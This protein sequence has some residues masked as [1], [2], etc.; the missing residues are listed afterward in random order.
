MDNLSLKLTKLKTKGFTLVELS[1]VIVIIGLIVAGVVGGQAI[2]NQAKLRKVITDY[3]AYKVAF[4]A[5]KLEYNKLPGD[6]DNATDY[7]PSASTGNGDNNGSIQFSETVTGQGFESL[8][9]FQ[10]LA[11]ADIIPGS[12]SY[13]GNVWN[14][15]YN[16]DAGPFPNSIY[17]PYTMGF[18]NARMQVGMILDDK[19]PAVNQFRGVM[20]AKDMFSVDTKADDG[21]VTGGAIRALSTWPHQANKCVTGA[22]NDVSATYVLTD[23]DKSCRPVLL[24]GL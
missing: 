2:V 19:V 24:Y 4:N 11:L 22:F 1:I 13:T 9:V 3:S 20:T 23:P 6:M 15:P 17:R 7:W 21:V 10:H 16:T 8:R 18:Y 12:Y 5:F 14:P